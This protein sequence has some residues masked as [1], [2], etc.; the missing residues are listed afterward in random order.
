M[1]RLIELTQLDCLS[2]ATILSS[3]SGTSGLDAGDS[4]Y[5]MTIGMVGQR[6][7]VSSTG[8]PDVQNS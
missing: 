6:Y 8:I 7:M 2:V 4:P 5:S 1:V 3:S